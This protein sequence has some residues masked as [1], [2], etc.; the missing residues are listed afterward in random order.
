[1]TQESFRQFVFD[2]T[3]RV[4]EGH[5]V[6][7]EEALRLAEA[8][9]PDRM[10]L[11]A[12]ANRIRELCTDGQVH[13]CSI[14]NVKSGRCSE[15][16][17]FCSQSVHFD[18]PVEEYPF[19]DQA[20]VEKHIQL[21]RAAGSQALGLVA[22]WKGLRKGPSLD[23]VLE[24]IRGAAAQGSDLQI[25]ASL[26]IVAD[27]DIPVLLKEAGLDT[28][29]HNL[30]T[31][32]GFF[33]EVCQ[34][35]SYDE[36]I[37][38]LELM[39]KAGLRRCS[40]GIFNMGES[41]ADRVDLALTLRDLGVEV[42]PLN[43]LNPMQG[44]PMGERGLLEPLECLTIIATYRF[45]LPDRQIMVAGGR[46]VNLRELQS[47]MFFAGASHTMAGHYL[48]SSGRSP[49][50]DQQ[51]IDDLGLPTPKR[52]ESDVGKQGSNHLGALPVLNP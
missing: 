33:G 34:S 20:T 40:G 44:T 14:V 24:R 41:N 36:R 52:A 48:T 8:Q 32:R 12:G 1:M 45:I 13:R 29:N 25:D 4:L 21:A 46:E 17:G 51:L 19:V 11:F 23:R 35:H 6:S 22:A 2:L 9:G 18:S 28:Y 37:Q 38:T 16:C 31:S 10:D 15:D 47:M 3:T 43:F 27:P 42:V 49:V 26:G 7:R 50:D 39:G 5:Q 30:E